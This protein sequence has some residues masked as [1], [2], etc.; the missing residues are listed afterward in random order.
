M[1]QVMISEVNGDMANDF[2]H[3][4]MRGFQE[5]FDGT[6][7]ADAIAK[8]RV[9]H[10]LWEQDKALIS[11]SPFF[12]IATS[13]ADHVDCSIKAGAPGFVKTIDD[14]AIEYPEYDGNS[15]YRTL[16]NI[17]KNH[18]VGLLFINVTEPGTKLRIKGTARIFTDQH[19][20]SRHHGAKAVVRITGTFFP[21]C[22]RYLPTLQ[23]GPISVHVPSEENPS[24]PPPEWKTRSY[25][26]DIL[27]QNDP[28][29]DTIKD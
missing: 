7:V 28:H 12:F 25:I 21:N 23:T 29:K 24:P 18:H 26:K 27:P 17:A 6:R 9:H 16:G 19:H 14:T 8:H 1:T 15:M 10:K 13:F 3:E 4:G 2:F 20:L 22:P 11:S 5:D